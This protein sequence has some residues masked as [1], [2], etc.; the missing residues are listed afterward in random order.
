MSTTPAETAAP[1]V[2]ATNPEGLPGGQAR[3]TTGH[4]IRPTAELLGYLAALADLGITPTRV[5]GHSNVIVFCYPIGDSL[6]CLVQYPSEDDALMYDETDPVVWKV[7]R[8]TAD[9]I[10]AGPHL[11]CTVYEGGMLGIWPDTVNSSPDATE[12][13]DTVAYT[14]CLLHGEIEDVTIRVR[15]A[16]DDDLDAD[17]AGQE[18]IEVHA[19]HC[20][21]PECCGEC[22]E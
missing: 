7:A 14:V 4:D 10:L 19:Q 5:L 20:Y 6:R 9:H 1:D 17:D 8:F 3:L 2:I 15:D 16:D 22:L 11:T 18:D 21:K 13:G 12:D